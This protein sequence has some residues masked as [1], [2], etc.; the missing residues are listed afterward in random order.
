MNET[1]GFTLRSLARKVREEWEQQGHFLTFMQAKDIAAR[2]ILDG[3]QDRAEA[4]TIAALN[5]QTYTPEGHPIRAHAIGQAAQGCLFRQQSQGSRL[6]D[7]PLG[8]VEKE[9]K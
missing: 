7:W 3:Y 4:M 8:V 9:E 6:A 1:Y 5:L 2:K